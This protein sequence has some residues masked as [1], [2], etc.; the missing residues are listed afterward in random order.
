MKGSEGGGKEHTKSN[1]KLV[2]MTIVQTVRS[3]SMGRSG[4]TWL[5]PDAVINYRVKKTGQ[6]LVE[7]QGA[8]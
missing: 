2:I 4:R 6:L 1:E 8:E 5:T 7:K 3:P